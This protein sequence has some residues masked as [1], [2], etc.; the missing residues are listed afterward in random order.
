MSVEQRIEIVRHVKK[1]GEE[2]RNAVRGI[3]QEVRKQI[4]ASG[5]G[6]IRAVQEATDASVAEIDKLIKAEVAEL[7]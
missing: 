4:D 3:R 7:A 5:C 2:A 6:S 1:L